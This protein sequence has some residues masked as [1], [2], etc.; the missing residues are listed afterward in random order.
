MTA[1]SHFTNPW[2]TPKKE[3]LFSLASRAPVPAGIEVDVLRADTV[4][5]TLK[6]D[7][8][9]N[10]LG[11]ASTKCFFDMLK[12]EKLRS[13]EDNN[14]KVSLTTSQG[15]LIQCQE[16]SNLVCKLLVKSQMQKTQLNL[17]TLMGYSLSP[18]PHCLGTADRFFAKTNKASVMHFMTED[19]S[20]LVTYPK[21]SM[22][23]QDGNALFHTM[24]NLAP[25]FRGITLQLL[26]LMLPKRDFVFSTGSYHPGQSRHWRG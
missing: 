23:I 20:E 16:Q 26:D 1:I 8:I 19:N 21:D 11:Y 12:R 13:T 4:G 6:E 17:N 7:F 10:R 5:K 25:T 3:K 2:R 24:T 15:K 18:V 14:K 9:H 22:L